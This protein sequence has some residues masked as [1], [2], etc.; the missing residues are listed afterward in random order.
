MKLVNRAWTYSLTFKMK[1]IIG[2]LLISI[3]T[4]LLFI[5]KKYK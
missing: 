5:A 1:N 3:L 4:L 2:V